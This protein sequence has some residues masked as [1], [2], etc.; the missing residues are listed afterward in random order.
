[1]KFHCVIISW[2]NHCEKSQ[3]IAKSVS[4][5]VDRLTV[6]YS[7]ELGTVESGD[8]YWHKVPNDFFYG[9]KFK[10]ALDLTQSDEILLLIQADANYSNWKNLIERCR[11]LMSDNDSIGVWAPEIYDTSWTTQRVKIAENAPSQINFVTQTDGIVFGFNMSVLNRLRQL[12]YENNNLGWGIDW[13]AICYAYTN[14]MYVIRDSSI[15]IEHTLGSGYSTSDAT[16]QMN[17]FFEQ[18]TTREII[19]YKLLDSY[20][21]HSAT[22]LRNYK[23]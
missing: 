1:M 12:N 3:R 14:N 16:A 20:S 8:G 13:I 5:Y 9:K 18:M 17:E 10:I 2:H 15:T 22:A 4:P 6:V 21:S 23:Y 19:M 11:K 7:N